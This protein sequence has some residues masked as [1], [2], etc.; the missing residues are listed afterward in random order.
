M[1]AAEASPRGMTPLFDAV[2]R[3]TALADA[4]APERA[5]LVVMTDG[6][7]ES[8][9]LSLD[10]LKRMFPGKEQEA[11][12]KVFTIAYGT[13]ASAS[14]LSGIAEAGDGSS[15]ESGTS[16]GAAAPIGV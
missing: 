3:L 15:S 13:Q 11:E 16:C 8:S 6:K 10:E 14:V 4:D 5:V 2:G 7:D 9:K 1:T 12:V